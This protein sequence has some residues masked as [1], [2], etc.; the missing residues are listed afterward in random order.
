MQTPG[1]YGTY[2]KIESYFNGGEFRLSRESLEK[3]ISLAKLPISFLLAMSTAPMMFHAHGR[4]NLKTD[5][6]DIVS[7]WYQ[8]PV[9]VCV[10][11]NQYA[12][13]G[14]E[15]NILTAPTLRW[16]LRRRGLDIYPS[17]I[18]MHVRYDLIKDHAQTIVFNELYHNSELLSTLLLRIEDAQE[19]CHRASLSDSLFVH[20]VYLNQTI[21]RWQE[22]LFWIQHEVSEYVTQLPRIHDT[23][24][25][26]RCWSHR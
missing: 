17:T 20:V 7:F 19:L 13:V 11:G 3:L 16:Q 9:R 25:Q 1:K 26:V 23:S 4:H 21:G 12:S 18:F 15:E 2:G 22:T 24:R 6:E 8:I 10:K 5:E 14:M